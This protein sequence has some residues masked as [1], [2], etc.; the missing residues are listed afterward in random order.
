MGN[1]VV[2]LLGYYLRALICAEGAP[3]RSY[4][5][6]GC[7]DAPPHNK[8]GPIFF[9]DRLSGGDR[10]FHIG[11]RGGD[12]ID[13]QRR[14]FRRR[15]RGWRSF[16]APSP[17]SA[18]APPPTSL[19]MARGRDAGLLCRRRRGCAGAAA[20][21]RGGGGGAPPVRGA[22]PPDAS[23]LAS[24]RRTRPPWATEGGA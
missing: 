12:P 13:G 17:A 7:T 19:T 8:R 24:L 21:A 14:Q 23:S 1:P 3:T 9:F 4:G 16:L 22:G 10:I 5:A 15:G 11:V 2:C 18:A 6:S 20:G